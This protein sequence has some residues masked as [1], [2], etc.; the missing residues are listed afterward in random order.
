MHNLPKFLNIPSN[1]KLSIS[2]GNM[3]TNGCVPFKIISNRTL[4]RKDF[5]ATLNGVNAENPSY[6][7]SFYFPTLAQPSFDKT[8]STRLNM[9]D[10]LSQ[11]YGSANCYVVSNPG[12]F[13]FPI[14]YGNSLNA[15]WSTNES[16][17]IFP[18][19]IPEKIKPYILKNFVDHNNNYIT[20]PDIPLT[21]PSLKVLWTDTEDLVTNLSIST[22]SLNNRPKRKVIKF[23]VPKETITYGNAIIGL[24]NDDTIVWSW[25]IW[26]TEFFNRS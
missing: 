7:N 21:N 4:D 23:R 12:I 16:S 17:Y 20:S 18:G 5:T 9:G 3:Q 19:T 10:E 26:V 24:F 1:L 14:V 8:F 22:L 6:L 11:Y 2:V 13:S 25:H 15:D